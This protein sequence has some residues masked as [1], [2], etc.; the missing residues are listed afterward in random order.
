MSEK[1]VD[2]MFLGVILG[3]SG[4]GY[5]WNSRKV[6]MNSSYRLK[7]FGFIYLLTAGAGIVLFCMG[8]GLL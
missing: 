2:F 3:I 1:T 5:L 7:G 6:R 8:R 4:F